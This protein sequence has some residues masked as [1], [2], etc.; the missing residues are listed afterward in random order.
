[1]S[2]TSTNLS[3]SLRNQVR[4]LIGDTSNSTATEQLSDGEIDWILTQR[5]NV[6][7]AAALAARQIAS[8]NAEEVASKTVGPLTLTYAE[9]SSQWLKKAADLDAQ[10]NKGMGSAVVPFSGGIS[11]T[12]K[13]TQSNDDD[14]DKPWFYRGMHDNPDDSQIEYSY[15]VSTST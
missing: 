6:Y 3:T 5:T 13:E 10:A 1:M 8:Q 11:E 12:D 4:L 2:Y 7:R 15:P 9:R 14:W